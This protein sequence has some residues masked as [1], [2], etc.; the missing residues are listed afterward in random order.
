MIPA[1]VSS[2]KLEALIPK[3]ENA[4]TSEDLVRLYLEVVETTE[5]APSSTTL[6]AVAGVT[7]SLCVLNEL[8]AIRKHLEESK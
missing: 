2:E 7:A 3:L 1:S 8:K 4:K 5:T 6:L